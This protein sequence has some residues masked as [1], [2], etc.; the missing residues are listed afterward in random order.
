MAEMRKDSGNNAQILLLEA[1]LHFGAK[2][3]NQSRN[4]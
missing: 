1:G 2:A 3:L 4:P